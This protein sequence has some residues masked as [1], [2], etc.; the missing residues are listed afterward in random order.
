M[1]GLG[2]GSLQ[3]TKGQQHQSSLVGT[4]TCKNIWVTSTLFWLS[5]LHAFYVYITKFKG[6][7]QSHSESECT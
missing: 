2:I 7:Y 5:C 3:K 1:R 6:D 4:P